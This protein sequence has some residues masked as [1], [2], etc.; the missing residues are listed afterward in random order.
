MLKEEPARPI[1]RLCGERPAR[2]QTKLS[3]KGFVKYKTLC[4]ACEN[5]PKA[6]RGLKEPKCEEC[7]GIFHRCQLDI[8]H[9]DHNHQNNSPENLQ[10]LCANCHRLLHYKAKIIL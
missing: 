2:R 10:T 4:G 8:H 7:G 5:I 9:K 1:C 3:A 6:L